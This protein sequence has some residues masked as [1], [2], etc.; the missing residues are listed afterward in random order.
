MRGTKEDLKRK[1]REIVHLNNAQI[2]SPMPMSLSDVIQEVNRREH[3]RC[4][5]AKLDLFTSN[6]V[7]KIKQG[8]VKKESC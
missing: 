2:G 1:Y 7:E 4:S 8:K 5:A 6:K 3:A